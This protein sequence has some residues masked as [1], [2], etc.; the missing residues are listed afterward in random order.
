M[1]DE[2]YLRP[3]EVCRL[4]HICPKTLYNWNHTGKI[5]SITTQGGRYR[6]AKTE[7]MSFLPTIIENKE[8]IRESF[9]YCRVSTASQKEDLQRQID[10]FKTKYP[11]H[12]IIKDIGSG[13]NFKRKGLQTLLDFAIKGNI[14]E[15]VVTHKD[16]LCRFGFDLIEKI[17][18]SSNGKIVVLNQRNTS[19][20]DE[21]VND[22]LSI[23]TVFSSR[24]Y[25]LRSHTIKNK[26]KETIQQSIKDSKGQVLTD[27]RRED[28]TPIDDEAI[29]LVL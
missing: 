11:N 15:I 8:E 14:K 26:I 25:G 10:F 20:Q 16:R 18:S 27:G 5:E 13:L 28:E 29:T 7:V 6:Y 4:L 1:T 9:C 24:M 3:N 19:P 23:I 2:E 17:V 22:L 21:L 12:T